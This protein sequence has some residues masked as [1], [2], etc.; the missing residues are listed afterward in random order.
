[1]R[2]ASHIDNSAVFQALPPY[3]GPKAK[4]ALVDFNV[5]AAKADS[6]IGRGLRTFFAA[7]LANSG[8]FSVV[9][10]EAANPAA[11]QQLSA[12]LIINVTVAEFQPQASGGRTGIGGGG[13]VSSGSL[14]GLLGASPN[15]AHIALDLYIVDAVTSKVIASTRLKGQASDSSGVNSANLLGNIPLGEILYKYGH[16]PMDKAIRICMIEAVRYVAQNVPPEYYKT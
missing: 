1:M 9:K 11:G 7:A 14:G 8:R 3:T 4:I 16:T 15:K 13:S 6:D 12:D 5:T 10:Y 2:T